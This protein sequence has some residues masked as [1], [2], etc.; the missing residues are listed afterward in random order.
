MPRAKRLSASLLSGE[1]VTILLPHFLPVELFFN[2]LP[3]SLCKSAAL[4]G[5]FDQTPKMTRESLPIPRREEEPRN[6]VLDEDPVA[7]HVARNARAPAG[8]GLHERVAESLAV[9]GQHKNIRGPE[10]LGNV[11]PQPREFHC[12]RVLPHE[13]MIWLVPA[14]RLNTR[15][16]K[17][18]TDRSCGG[19]K[20]FYSLYRLQ[21]SDIGHGEVPPSPIGRGLGRG[22]ECCSINP[23]GNDFRLVC[24]A[25]P[26]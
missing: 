7:A 9:A 24:D 16:G 11:V 10:H 12:S 17:I 5:I 19:K 20:I 1:Q 3:C 4:R 6:T 2:A 25:E 14:D 18:A 21:P 15:T 13:R 23:R 8:H 22:E 26:I